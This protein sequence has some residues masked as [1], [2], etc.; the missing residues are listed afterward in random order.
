MYSANE[1]RIDSVLRECSISLLQP[2]GYELDASF[3]ACLLS[4]SLKPNRPESLVEMMF[5]PVCSTARFKC[6]SY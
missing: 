6:L 1:I 4:L 3:L 5:M 2:R